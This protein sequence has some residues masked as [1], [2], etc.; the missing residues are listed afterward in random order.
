[1]VSAEIPVP[2]SASLQPSGFP[3]SVG[4]AL[5]RLVSF[6]GT[7]CDFPGMDNANADHPYEALAQAPTILYA[8]TVRHYG[9]GSA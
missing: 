4:K 8:P 7:S 9:V 3:F 6:A 1:M 2:T 5:Y